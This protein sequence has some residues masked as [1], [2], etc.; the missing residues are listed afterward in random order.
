M[1][2][3]EQTALDPVCGM[4]VDT[5]LGKPS[6]DY[7]GAT[8]HFCCGG[9]QTKFSADPT[10]Y[11]TA[12]DPVC[13]MT[14]DTMVGKPTTRHLGKRYH[15]CCGGCRTKFEAEPDRYLSAEASSASASAAQA[16]PEG[17]LWI[18]PMCPEVES[19]VPAACPT[20]GMAL[21]ASEVSL[22]EEANPELVDMSRRFWVSLGLTLPVFVIAMGEML[23]PQRFSTLL[24]GRSAVW[25]QL[26]LASP[27]V[28]WAGRPFFERGWTSV[29]TRN[30]NMFTLIAIGTGVAFLYSLVA[31]LAPGIFP[32]G[33]E[34]PE[35]SV[36]VYFE[37]ATVIITLVLLGQVLELR[38]RS[39]TNKALRALLGLAPNTARILRDKGKEEDIPLEEVVVGDTLR[40]R[41]G[42][43]VPV[44]GLVLE[45]ESRVDE[46]M[47]TGEPLPASKQP[48]DTVTGATVNGTGMMLIRAERV[49]ADTLLSQI[50]RMVSEAQRSRAPI[51]KV[52]DLV[53]GYFVPVVVGVSV[54]T[55]TAWALLGSVSPLAYALINAVAVLIIACPCALGLATPVSIMVGTGRGAGAGVLIKNA[56]ALELLEKV[57]ILLVDKTGTLTEGSPRLTAVITAEGVDEAEMLRQVG[58]LERG[59][60]HPLAEA[61][62]AGVEGRGIELSGVSDFE[63]VT[64]MGVRG[65]VEGK[66]VAIGNARLLEGLGV[67]AGGLADRADSL[68]EEGQT[69][70]HVVLGDRLAGLI[71]VSDPIKESTPEAIRLLREAGLEIVMVTGDNETTALAVARKLG[72]EKV[73]AEVLPEDKVAVVK[74]YQE[75]G[76]K[77][78]MAGDGINDAPALA[79]AE[80]GLAMGTGTAVAME[81]A[82][83]TLVQGDLRG[84]IRARRLSRG[85]MRNIR[86]NLF[87][88]FIYNGVGVPIAALGLL[89]PMIAA[90]AMSVS[91]VSV[92]SNSLR[93]RKLDL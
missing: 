14:V 93:L 70:M 6:F 24:T 60:E 33:F 35:G 83:V 10:S 76:R 72:L 78:A 37:A 68:R 71:G 27:V 55:F 90:A 81:S 91:S 88:A 51:Q 26:L 86:Q 3:A 13:G 43:K 74:R 36:A 5:T 17:A 67:E 38:A 4:T 39:Q 52:A 1:Q 77:V 46:S 57:D 20:C 80:V 53:S 59:S 22:E 54:L 9:C 42:D 69:V 29:K 85:V 73:E 12:L 50:V 49:G 19:T 8:Y 32:E 2:D 23:L 89:N 79:Q 30:L 92:I 28:F 41:P 18:C 65:R 40:V 62:V 61:I 56:E 48:G 15:F 34:G 64:G 75:L 84:I 66:A 87:F 44:D 45:G 31:A 63:S 82:A 25:V 7:E 21:E 58:S 11:L 16:V 47:I